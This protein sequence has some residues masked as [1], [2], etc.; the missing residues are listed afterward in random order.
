MTISRLPLAE[1]AALVCSTFQKHGITTVLTGGSCVTLYSEGRY[2]SKDI[3]LVLTATSD[4]KLV[5]SAL[6]EL[7][8]RCKGRTYAH[9]KVKYTVDVLPAP[10]TIGRERVRCPV[11]R[12]VRGLRLLMLSPTDCVKDRLSAFFYWDD[13]QA[14]KQAL[15]VARAQ[16]VNRVEIRR[17]AR[18]EKMTAR[19]REFEAEM[20]A[21]GRGR[22]A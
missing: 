7:G 13:R 21:V 16:R 4:I 5:E 6:A 18:A 15:L 20:R 12:I 8:F 2:V 10:P 14:L 9:P 3:D 11:A 22:D 19:L 17:W 1:L